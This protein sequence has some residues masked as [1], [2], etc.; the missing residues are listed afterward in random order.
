MPVAMWI[1]SHPPAFVVWVFKKSLPTATFFTK[2]TLD[3][4]V[5]G[6]GFYAF[7]RSITNDSTITSIHLP[8]ISVSS[9]AIIFQLVSHSL[10][11]YGML[12]FDREFG[13]H[14]NALPDPG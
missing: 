3:Q 7:T 4:I 5:L 8:I 10:A 2:S 13:T 11:D 1:R 14:S 12:R 9:G 6:Q